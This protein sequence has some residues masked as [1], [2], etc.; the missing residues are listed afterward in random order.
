MKKENSQNSQETVNLQGGKKNFTI[1]ELLIVIKG[2]KGIVSV[3]ANKL[4]CAW[5]TA[6]IYIDQH[7]EAK[8]AL[9]DENETILDF[10]ESKLYKR[11]DGEDMTAIKFLLATKGKKRGYTERTELTG[12]DGDVV[13]IE[14]I[15]TL[16][17]CLD[18][19]SEEDRAKYF[20]LMDKIL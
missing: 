15:N 18:K 6:K 13:K 2:S 17:K 7:E 9:S 19:M 20:E 14:N 4:D 10:A 3:V 16:E 1:E 5:S 11:I 12:A 8:Q